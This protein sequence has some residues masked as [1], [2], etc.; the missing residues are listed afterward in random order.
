MIVFK[1]T[2]MQCSHS[3]HKANT[4]ALRYCSPQ[5][6]KRLDC[7]MHLNCHLR[8]R[9]NEPTAGCTCESSNFYL[10]EL[11]ARIGELGNLKVGDVSQDQYGFVMDLSG[12]TG[13]RTPRIILSSLRKPNY[14]YILYVTLVVLPYFILL[15]P[16]PYPVCS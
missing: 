6:A 16:Y 13:H 12:K 1:L 11:G 15:R 10:Y 4:L 5:S 14:S 2:V 3:W 7:F 9:I 8:E